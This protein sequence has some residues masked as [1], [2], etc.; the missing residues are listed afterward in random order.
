MNLPTKKQAVVAILAAA[1]PL[2]FL[3]AC[4]TATK[5][6]TKTAP[7]TVEPT[8]TP[9]PTPA[10]TTIPYGDFA[11]A[12]ISPAD[13]ERLAQLTKLITLVPESFNSAVFLD[14]ESLKSNESLADLINPEI[15]G[16]DVA[17][18]SIASGLVSRI[19]VAADTQNRS[20]VT[21]FQSEF[22]IGDMLRLAGGFGIN[23]GGDGPT[24]YEGHD[25]WGINAFGTVLAMAAADDTTG[26]AAAGQAIAPDDARA[27]AEA[28]L[29]AFDGRS[30]T[31]LDTPGLSGLLADVPSGFAAAVLSGCSTVPLFDDVQELSVCTGV[32]VTADILPGDLVVFHSLVGFPDQAVAGLAME[33]AADALAKENRSQ[34]FD[35]LGVRQEGRN[36]RIRL[37]VS[38][39]KFAEVFQ[40]LAPNN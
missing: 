15:L 4:S 23:L 38:L 34:G 40:L 25:V 37:I 21:P 13:P 8:A 3:A 26:V 29:D 9:V 19:A 7:P 17:L 35:D 14:L 28:S 11:N 6:A 5:L 39:P 36:L 16:M 18:P 1:F 33:Q 30:A 31:L 24:S 2:V 32:V 27:L 22:S 10:A 12:K 20:L